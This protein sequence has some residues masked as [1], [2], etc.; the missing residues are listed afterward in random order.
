MNEEVRA[1]YFDGSQLCAQVGGDLFFTEDDSKAMFDMRFLK[2]LC[3]SCHFN[4]PCLEYA[5]THQVE[6][7]WAGTGAKQRSAMRTRLGIKLI[8]YEYSRNRD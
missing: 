5:L 1:P 4:K 2:A 3:G 6:G 7:I 8:E